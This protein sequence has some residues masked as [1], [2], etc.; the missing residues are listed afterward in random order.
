M[1]SQ[2]E[3]GE[4]NPTFATLWHLTQALGLGIDDLVAA[5]TESLPVTVEILD[6]AA[7]PRLGDDESGA[8]LW[9]L[10]PRELVGGVEWYELVLE[11]AGQ[12]AS[13]P[14]A[15]GTR[16]HVTVLE[17]SII[18]RS[19]DAIETVTLGATA[20]YAADV[21][22]EIANPSNEPARVLLVVLGSETP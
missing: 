10:A 7:T 17:G 16:E 2:V 5:S 1:L 6:R 19:A 12:L 14:H 13:A 9:L 15:S 11:P 22:H 4:A 21:E 18:V 8:V 3:R 20:R